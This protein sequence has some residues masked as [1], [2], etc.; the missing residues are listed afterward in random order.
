MAK[1]ISI[2]SVLMMLLLISQE[3][4][5]EKT[6][7]IYF[8]SNGISYVSEI[9]SIGGWQLIGNNISLIVEGINKRWVYFPLLSTASVCAP[10]GGKY[11]G[12]I[13]IPERAK[14]PGADIEWGDSIYHLDSIYVNVEGCVE[15]IFENSPL[16]ESVTFPEN[17]NIKSVGISFK[18]CSILR[19]VNNMDLSII[20]PH[21]F[22]NCFILGD[23]DLSKTT[24]IGDY[25]FNNCRNLKD[26]DLSKTTSIGDYGFNNCRN[27]KDINLSKL[28]SIG[29]YAFSGCK[30]ITTIEFKN[31][32]KPSSGINGDDSSKGEG[33]FSGCTSLAEVKGF[34][35]F[36]PTDDR[37]GDKFFYHCK[38]L[39][40]IMIY[41]DIEK[42]G[43]SAFEGCSNLTAI[44]FPSDGNAYKSGLII[45]KKAFYDCKKLIVFSAWIASAEEYAFG[46]C[47][48]LGSIVWCSDG[49]DLKRY[50]FYGCKALDRLTI[51][52]QSGS[53]NHK[54]EYGAFS[55]CYNIE[56]VFHAGVTEF[57]TRESGAFPYS[58]EDKYAT[59]YAAYKQD[60]EYNQEFRDKHN[61]WSHFTHQDVAY[62]DERYWELGEAGIFC[63][64]NSPHI[65]NGALVKGKYY[66]DPMIDGKYVT[67][68]DYKAF[69]DNQRLT[70]VYIP[71]QI[72]EI[73]GQ[74]FRNCSMLTGI[75]VYWATPLLFDKNLP[76]ESQPFAGVDFE[77]VTLY[78]PKGC[79]EIY[80]VAN[81]WKRFTNIVETDYESQTWTPPEDDK[82]HNHRHNHRD[83][84]EKII[85]FLDPLAEEICVGKW[86]AN[87]SGFLSEKEA[88]NV[89]DLGLNFKGT[90]ITSFCEQSYFTG[91]NSIAQNEFADCA[92]LDSITIPM[93]ITAIGDYA[94]SG[95][96]SLKKVFTNIQNPQAFNDNV[97][98]QTAYDQAW[99]VV[100]VGTVN[101][102]KET[103]GWKNFNIIVEKGSEPN[104]EDL[105][106]DEKKKGDLTGDSNV[107][108]ADLEKMV[109]L[110]MSG[111]YETNADLNSDG[112]VNAADIV[113]L[114]SIIKNNSNVGSGYFW[115]GTMKPNSF[116]IATKEGVVTTY[117]SL[118]EALSHSPSFA[119][120]AGS[121]AVVLCPSS[122]NVNADN[123]VFQDEESGSNYN[124][125]K[126]TTDIEGHDVFV[127]TTKIGATTTVVLK[128]KADAN[129]N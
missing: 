9:D 104:P 95:C 14:F 105:N 63:R 7:S 36:R 40:E 31:S 3:S 42:I 123:V 111:M 13:I 74:A 92:K 124:L 1:K 117:R 106:E 121:Y 22:D 79:K 83:K 37:I 72:R 108:E 25:G 5:A 98:T 120:Q 50:S 48:Q 66:I 19:T 38:S 59:L 43:K 109:G 39:K 15:G 2:L 90:E 57:P 41:D 49:G 12:E 70:S 96:N 53:E 30:S 84:S 68:I 65:I 91:L 23:I 17:S 126:D 51:K 61:P 52:N 10:K 45:G 56:D 103:A 21:Q 18:D 8:E 29:D 100:P 60:D 118:S 107:N 87:G 44:V 11:S 58:I 81:E 89:S 4:R 67:G 34:E 101:I 75:Y 32:V 102:Y 28:S 78:V 116:N 16:L 47:E 122:W 99:L 6:K 125:K 64:E 93:N 26:I 62:Y 71:V 20:S 114:I 24:S 54:I 55:G 27:L 76:E 127:T 85:S 112:V 119:I 129:A 110:I 33:V 46:Y 77:K 97:F 73:G 82:S 113:E 115:I 35:L 128:T 80:Q 69:K 86:D 94:F 88:A